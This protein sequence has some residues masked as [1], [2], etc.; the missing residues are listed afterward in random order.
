MLHSLKGTPVNSK[1]S[2][3]VSVVIRSYNRM[4]SMIELARICQAQDYNNFEILVIEQSD[5]ALRK[6]YQQEFAVLLEDQRMNILYFGRVGPAGARNKAVSHARGEILI[7]IDDDDIPADTNWIKNHVKNFHDPQCVAVI[8]REFVE[9]DEN[10]SRHNTKKLS[11]LLALLFFENAPCTHQTHP[12][13]N[14][15]CGVAGLQ[16]RDPKRGD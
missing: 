11:A 7:F 14:R 3:F 5:D 13:L 8:G 15:C 4:E 9:G 1:K 2:P 6:K 16:H 10:P 12:A